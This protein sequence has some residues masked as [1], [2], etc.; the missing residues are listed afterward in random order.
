ME[1]GDGAANY[2]APGPRAI[3]IVRCSSFALRGVD[4]PFARSAETSRFWSI[5]AH[6]LR[7]L[8]KNL[9]FLIFLTRKIRSDLFRSF[10]PRTLAISALEKRRLGGR[11]QMEGTNKFR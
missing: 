10:F 1:S 3:V 9:Q 8:A 7:F 6:F 2:A 4:V 11:E 5:L